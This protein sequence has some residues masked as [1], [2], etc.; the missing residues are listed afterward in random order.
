M[1]NAIA[2]CGQLLFTVAAIASI[3]AF[4]GWH[5]ELDAI[6]DYWW[7]VAFGIGAAVLS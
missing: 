6:H 7:A 5:S 1:G 3:A 4:I 2:L